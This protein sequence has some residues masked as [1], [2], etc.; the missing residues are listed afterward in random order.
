M[1][2]LLCET[3]LTSPNKSLAKDL[4]IRAHTKTYFYE[5]FLVN[6]LSNETKN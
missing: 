3:K 5:C 1:L 2:I 6:L 4:V